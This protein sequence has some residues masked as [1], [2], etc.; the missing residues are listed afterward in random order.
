[1]SGALIAVF[2]NQRQFATVPGAP[3]IGTATATGSTTATV[4]YT[5]PASNGGSV[6]T[7]YTATSSPSGITGTLSQAGSGTITVSGLA[8][9]TS[10]TFTVTATN[11]IGTGPASAASNSITTVSGYWEAL[12]YGAGNSTWRG[13]NVVASSGKMYVTGATGSSIGMTQGY[14]TASTTFTTS[15]ATVPTFYGST[16][17]GDSGVGAAIALDSS[18][19]VYVAGTV[20]GNRAAFLKYSSSGTFTNKKDFTG[21]SQTRG[22]GVAVDS[23]GNIF[24]SGEGANGI[25][26]QKYNSAY[27]VQWRRTLSAVNAGDYFLT[28]IALASTG[29]VYVS[30][31]VTTTAGCAIIALTSTGTTSWSRK[32][33]LGSDNVQAGDI[34]L[35]S[36]GNVYVVLGNVTLDKAVVAKYNSSGTIQWQ[37]SLSN[38]YGWAIALDSSDNV[39]M[40]GETRV[41][42]WNSSGTLQWQRV[43]GGTNVPNVRAIAVSGSSMYISGAIASRAVTFVLPTDG[44]KTGTFPTLATYSTTYAAGSATE[45]VGGMTDAALT[46]SNTADTTLTLRNATWTN[47]TAAGMTR[48]TGQ[49]T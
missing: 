19:N 34:K 32:L 22:G 24:Y 2:A 23:S 35:D 20:F 11:A 14:N 43:F 7:S 17:C 33:T 16:C 28:P 1:M 10:Y 49:I 4:A 37:R 36:A 42:K 38:C 44:S 45:A 27:T 47:D 39:Y 6:I 12:I 30:A 8:A 25:F 31:T 18:E 3:T 15:W 9:S 29:E 46:T 40:A 48:T 5:A 13:K 21:C 26:V 41:A